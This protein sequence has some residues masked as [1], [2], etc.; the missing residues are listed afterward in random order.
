MKTTRFVSFFYLILSGG[1]SGLN[2][3]LVTKA[4]LHWHVPIPA[5]RTPKIKLANK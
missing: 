2:P 1:L 3:G 4:S 5:Y